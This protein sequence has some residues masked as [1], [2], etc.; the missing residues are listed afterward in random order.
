MTEHHRSEYKCWIIGFKDTDEPPSTAVENTT[1]VTITWMDGW[2]GVWA[3]A[4]LV[5]MVA[6]FLPLWDK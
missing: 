1:L 4:T 6:D 3:D 5:V 2:M